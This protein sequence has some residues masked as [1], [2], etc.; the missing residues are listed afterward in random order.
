MTVAAREVPAMTILLERNPST[1]PGRPR[2]RSRGARPRRKTQNLLKFGTINSVRW[3]NRARCDDTSFVD[4]GT[5]GYSENLFVQK[6]IARPCCGR[7]SWTAGTW[8]AGLAAGYRS[9]PA[10]RTG[11]LRTGTGREGRDARRR[12]VL[13]GV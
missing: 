10:A 5:N 9:D 12:R 7:M 13:R 6:G 3:S 11:Q 8:R 1:Q 2:K 4:P